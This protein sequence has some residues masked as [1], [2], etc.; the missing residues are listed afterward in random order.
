MHINS[1][2]K[3]KSN[4]PFDLTC[5][6]IIIFLVSCGQKGLL[7]I[8]K[9]A[10]AGVTQWT[11]SQLDS[12]Q[13]AWVVDPVPSRGHV[14]GNHTLMIFSLSPSLPLSLKINK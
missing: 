4:H 3:Q 5:Y 9:I 11:E 6:F 7:E 8:Q 14:R 1:L 13:R 10:L 2:E 12:L